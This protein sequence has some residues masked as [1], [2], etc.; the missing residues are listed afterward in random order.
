MMRTLTPSLVSQSAR[1]RPVG[2]EP[3]I[4]TSLCIISSSFIS[5]AGR[6][7]Q[8]TAQR[9]AGM[10]VGESVQIR[11]IGAYP[12][13]NLAK[14]HRHDHRAHQREGMK[15]GIAWRHLAA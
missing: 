10:L 13:E 15:A 12:A 14:Q 7:Q 8:Q 11:R 5:F 2:P 9:R 3:T 6:G 4:S 1:T